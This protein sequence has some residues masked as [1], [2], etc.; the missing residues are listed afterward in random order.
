MDTGRS[1][2][3]SGLKRMK[4]FLIALWK[5]ESGG[6]SAVRFGFG[7]AGGIA[8]FFIGGPQ[9]AQLG[10][11]AGSVIGGIVAP[12]DTAGVQGQRLDPNQAMTSAYG[13]PI[14]IG[15]GRFVVGGT[16][17]YY[18]GFEEHEVEQETGGK[19]S[20]S[21]QTTRSYTYTGNFR[22]NWC[23]GPADA[24][25]KIW[26][27][28]KLFFDATATTEPQL[29][30]VKLH[31]PPGTQAIRLYLGTEDQLP[32]P[33][34]LS[35]EGINNTNAYRGI[36]GAFFQNFGLDDSG[37]TPPQMTALI[38]TDATE[39]L[40][41]DTLEGAGSGTFW[42]WQPGKASF[43]S[44]KNNR[45]SNISQTVLA[46]GGPGGARPEYPTMDSLGRLHVLSDG[47][48]CKQYSA[49]T[50]ELLRT[51]SQFRDP[52]TLGAI[53]GSLNYTHGRVFG[54]V[55][56]PLTG[57]LIG[58]L[59]W[60]QRDT[61]GAT[62][63]TLII[64]L[65]DM[66]GS[67]TGGVIINFSPTKVQEHGAVDSERFLWTYD[68]DAG[69]GDGVLNRYSPGDGQIIESYTLTGDG[70]FDHMCFDPVTNS[71]ILGDAAGTKGI[72][73]WS[74]DTHLETARTTGIS[75]DSSK[76]A[77]EWHNGP[78]SNGVL[79]LQTGS[80]L[81]TFR[82]F[83]IFTMT[84]DPRSWNPNTDWGLG[85]ST[86]HR[87]MYDE[88]RNAMMKRDDISQNIYWLYL[89]RKVG[90]LITVKQVVDLVAGKVGLTGIDIDT[91]NLTDQ[92][93]G[94]LIGTRMAANRALEPLRQFF[95]FNPV[96]EDFIIKFPLLGG[97]S[98]ATVPEDDL[99]AGD[100]DDP[101]VRT[102]RLAEEIMQE[103]ELPEVL[104]LVHANENSEYQPQIQRVK[105]PRSTTASKRRR[106]LGFPG[107]FISNSDAKQRLQSFLYQIW[108]KRRPVIFTT[109][110]RWLRLSPTDVVDVV[111]DGVTQQVILGQVD[112]GANN[113]IEFRGAA[114]DP[115]T[116]VS[117]TTGAEGVIP[118]QTIELVSP[119]EFFVVDMPIMRSQDAGFGAYFAGGP[120]GDGS[121]PGEEIHRGSDGTTFNPFQFISANRAVDHGFT[122]G[123]GILP[124]ADP[125]FWDRDTSFTIQ[126]LRG[127]LASSTEALVIA[128][129]ANVLI[130]G[131]EY[132]NFVTATDLG[133]QRYTISTLLRGRKGT[134]GE[135][136]L[137]T[138]SEKVIVPTEGTMI[139]RALDLTDLDV[140][141]FYKGVTRGGSLADGIRKLITVQG[142]SEWTW[143]VVHVVGSISANDWTINWKWRNFLRPEWKNL[144]AV[145]HQALFN[146]EIDVLS[147]P[148]GT[149]LAT[150]STTAS[151]NGS[152]I[153]AIDHDFFYDDAD[154]VVDFGSVQT[155]LTVKI[156]PMVTNIG[157]AFPKE[158]TLVGG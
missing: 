152:V 108:L 102:D 130:I 17:A 150:Y 143:S 54:G 104:E 75:Y 88:S 89:D 144:E 85:S 29:D 153:T 103:I 34:E 62:A 127:T 12:E 21:S 149:V 61:L 137:H 8:G 51:S 156:Y 70:A 99:A 41:L 20:G 121:F 129:G 123:A 79:M 50:L 109:A 138:V 55:L 72:M 59:L 4:N 69:S 154:Q 76:S 44:G 92:L 5:D 142:K 100:G 66:V 101:R 58:E 141:F 95:F 64:D 43:L 81:G 124:D 22:V 57:L 48:F 116:L 35:L 140:A 86:V 28:R 120:I 157:R 151:A 90:A 49:E 110:Q 136:G 15:L 60:T 9:G 42:E 132:V 68:R 126:M 87:G 77:P 91:S 96:S 119:S 93:H 128:T 125:D 82:K 18:P 53:T 11:L 47:G 52:I 56:N 139:R 106:T 148:G 134:E 27:N 73:R 84:L 94:Y 145:P 2:Q 155:T 32:D 146:Y 7:I 16:L 111:S 45:I 71:L 25:L 113:K 114:D 135:T 31:E 23:E 97:S 117:I 158:V 74:I 13:D 65:N 122:D 24:I 36:V 133:N 98:V 147:G 10:F 1:V 40:P 30:I 131:N 37:G 112:H 26:A 46:T 3:G 107:T 33:M 6:S 105:R 80:T 78:A 14:A 83:N 67:P 39:I 118:V 115:S 19:G 38:A 63:Q